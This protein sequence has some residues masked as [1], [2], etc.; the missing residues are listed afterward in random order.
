MGYRIYY[1]EVQG[2]RVG[3]RQERKPPIMDPA[4]TRA[5]LAGLEPGTK[6]RITVK[7]TTEA[8]EGPE[9]VPLHVLILLNTSLLLL[10]SP[11]WLRRI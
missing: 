1:Q 2:T 8:G 11:N 4:T 7:A 10:V 6:Y 5:K 3:P 9:L